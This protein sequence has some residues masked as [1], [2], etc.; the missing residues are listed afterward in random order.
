MY[1]PLDKKVVE[2]EDWATMGR[3]PR[4]CFYTLATLAIL[5]ALLFTCK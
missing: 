2:N 4:A 5:E 3:G 1:L